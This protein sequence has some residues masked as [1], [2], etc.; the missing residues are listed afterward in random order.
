MA[1][2]NLTVIRSK[3]IHTSVKF[4]KLL[5]LQFELHSHGKG[6]KHYATVDSETVFEIYPA[7]DK[8]PVTVGT[9]IGFKVNCCEQL[10]SILMSSGYNALTMPTK[11]PWGMRAVF[12]DPDNHRVEIIS[13]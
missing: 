1:R 5:G 8:F 11:S 10:S 12:V 6:P 9:R 7:S 13:I 3:D 4:Y 2:L